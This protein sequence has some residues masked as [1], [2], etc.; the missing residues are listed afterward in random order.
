MVSREVLIK[1]AKLVH[2]SLCIIITFYLSS[3]Y[4][5]G[6]QVCLSV[7]IPTAYPCL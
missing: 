6:V 1:C 4:C 3:A 7:L 2:I 5:S